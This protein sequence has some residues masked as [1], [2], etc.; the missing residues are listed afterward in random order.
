MPGRNDRK[1][2]RPGEILRA[3]R[4]ERALAYEDLGQK[5]RARAD[6]VIRFQTRSGA[7]C[8]CFTFF[9][10]LFHTRFFCCHSETPAYPG[11]EI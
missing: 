6:A 5:S 1:K 4:Y 8:R 11:N 10:G 7:S 2:G 9:F 3:L